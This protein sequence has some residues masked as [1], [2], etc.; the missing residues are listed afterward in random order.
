MEIPSLT[1]NQTIIDKFL[2]WLSFDQSWPHCGYEADGE[3]D[4]D[5]GSNKENEWVA[6]PVNK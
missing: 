6:V 2:D 4:V 1:V 5:E 3:K